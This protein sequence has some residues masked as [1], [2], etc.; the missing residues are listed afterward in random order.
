M[1]GLIA[2]ITMM[3]LLLWIVGINRRR[4]HGSTDLNPPLV[5]HDQLESNRYLKNV[6]N[7]DDVKSLQP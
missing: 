6:L 7:D 4:C 3:R 1:I 5:E 2:V